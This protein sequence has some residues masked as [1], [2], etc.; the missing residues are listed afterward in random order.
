M[1]KDTIVVTSPLLPD[2]DDF[3]AMLREIWDNKWITN[4]GEFHQRLEAALC[5]YLKV[6]YISL[7]TNGTLPLLTAPTGEYTNAIHGLPPNT[8]HQQ[9]TNLLLTMPDKCCRQIIRQYDFVVY[10]LYL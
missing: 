4:N 3:T 9:S 1:K 6:P 7:F 2:L 5:E 10:D 8:V